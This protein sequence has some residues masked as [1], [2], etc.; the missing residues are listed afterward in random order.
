MFFYVLMESSKIGLG[1]LQLLVAEGINLLSNSIGIQCA[2]KNDHNEST[3]CYESTQ[4]NL[5][6]PYSQPHH[7][8]FQ[9]F[10]EDED[11]KINLFHGLILF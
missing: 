7:K 1:F 9:G 4:L 10:R 6:V 8:V 11:P 5:M 3:Y 2:F